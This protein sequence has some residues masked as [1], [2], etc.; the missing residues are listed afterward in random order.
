M[1]SLKYGSE[2]KPKI[3][4][5]DGENVRRICPHLPMT[6]RIVH[7][8]MNKE[9]RWGCH[10][11]CRN[12]S[13]QSQERKWGYRGQKNNPGDKKHT[14]GTEDDSWQGLQAMDELDNNTNSVF[15]QKN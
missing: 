10:N 6:P 2:G 11:D 15:L 9:A 12:L 1:I 7:I 14:Q 3:S 13:H 8:D 5:E 4:Q